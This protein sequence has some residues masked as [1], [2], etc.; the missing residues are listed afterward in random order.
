MRKATSGVTEGDIRG[1]KGAFSIWE[2]NLM[3]EA[4]IADVME[5]SCETG[6]D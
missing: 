5:G 6:W 4:Q 2:E 3:E 1:N